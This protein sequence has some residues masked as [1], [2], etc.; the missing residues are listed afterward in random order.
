LIVLLSNF[1][2]GE[3]DFRECGAVD[4]IA[5]SAFGPHRLTAVWHR[6]CRT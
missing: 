5:K 6:I 2:D 1:A 3:L 4:Y